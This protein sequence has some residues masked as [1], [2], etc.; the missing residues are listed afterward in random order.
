MAIALSTFPPPAGMVAPKGP[1]MDFDLIRPML[2]MIAR[3]VK[4]DPLLFI[5][6]RFLYWANRNHLN[7]TTMFQFESH[8]PA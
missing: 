2:S 5:H 7:I 4:A 6:A 1:R 3:A 8:S